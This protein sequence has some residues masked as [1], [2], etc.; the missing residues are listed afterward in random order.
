MTNE[1]IIQNKHETGGRQT[2]S[3]AIR[4]A[5]PLLMLDNRLICHMDK[6]FSFDLNMYFFIFKY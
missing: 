1:E 2:V 4:S 6:P 3:Y 5:I